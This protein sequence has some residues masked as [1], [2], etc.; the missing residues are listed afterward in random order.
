MNLNKERIKAKLSKGDA[1]NRA[2]MAKI[3]KKYVKQ[4][5]KEAHKRAK[6]EKI[7]DDKV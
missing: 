1:A 7:Y 3:D 4:G 5:I 6:K 2:I